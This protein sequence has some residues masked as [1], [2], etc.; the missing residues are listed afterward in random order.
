MYPD[1]KYPPDA[2]AVG[3]KPPEAD[4][5]GKKPDEA[6]VVAKT[7][8]TAAGA[9]LDKDNVPVAGTVEGA[10]EDVAVFS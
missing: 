7:L 4:A 6:V 3:K 2:E 10:P 1:G 5:V 9:L 8:E